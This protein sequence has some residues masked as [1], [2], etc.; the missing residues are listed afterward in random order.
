MGDMEDEVECMLGLIGESEK[1]MGCWASLHHCLAISD[2]RIMEEL[3]YPTPLLSRFNISMAPEKRY[4]T[5][6]PAYFPSVP[7]IAFASTFLEGWTSY[8]SSMSDS[9]LPRQPLWYHYTHCWL[10]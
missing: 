4:C 3:V 9:L 1:N 7:P 10:S 8:S 5:N 2:Q 6:L